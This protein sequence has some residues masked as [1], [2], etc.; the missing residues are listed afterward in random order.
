MEGGERVGGRRGGRVGG[1]IGGG[2]RRE[3]WKVERGLEGGEEVEGEGGSKDAALHAVHVTV[4]IFHIRMSERSIHKQTLH[5]KLVVL[6]L[7]QFL[8]LPRCMYIHVHMY[9]YILHVYTYIL[10]N[11]ETE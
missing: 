7:S 4:R 2:G 1:R 6:C 10:A 3:H 11:S 5:K 9:V 8:S